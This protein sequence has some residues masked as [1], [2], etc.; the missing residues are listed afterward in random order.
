[1]GTLK[2]DIS[3]ELARNRRVFLILAWLAVAANSGPVLAI[4][5]A[6]LDG[7]L[8]PLL[9]D[10][11]FVNYWMGA[12]LS[13]RG[14]EK[15]LFAQPI[16]FARL[17]EVFG[18]QAQIR[19]WSYP[20]HIL[21]LLLPLG[22]LSYETAVA[23]FVLATFGLFVLGAEAFRR[24]EAPEADRLLLW[25]AVAAYAFVNIGAVQNGFLTGALMLLG[26]AFRRSNPV[27]AGLAFA[28]LTVKP[29]LGLLVPLLLLFER[30]WPA[31][32]WS[33]VFTILFIGLSAAVFGTGIWH[34]Y[35]GETAAY[36]QSVMTSWTGDFLKMMPTVFA[37]ARTIGM[38][39][40]VGLMMQWPVSL[41]AAL[42]ACWLFLRDPSPLGRSFALLCATFLV[43]P[44]GFDYD[45][46]ALAVSA[47]LLVGAPGAMPRS[48]RYLVVAVA[49]APAFV[50]HLGFLAIPI[51]P[52]LLF[53]ALFSR[54]AAVRNSVPALGVPTSGGT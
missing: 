36:Q 14:E 49:V 42:F 12:H 25:G 34:A 7:V 19:G 16:Y 18:P 22:L 6:F 8:S 15:D 40:S 53:A 39:S 27:L 9:V 23:L 31:I 50:V 11:D 3:S 51:T 13:L 24:S 44:Y 33:G 43:S 26:L 52:L 48:A 30:N 54:V 21:L 45:M 10:K 17:E 32:I 2:E 41:A 28:L 29:Q 20:P 5:G 1:M 47:A 4:L 37:S 38:D 35:I 46:G